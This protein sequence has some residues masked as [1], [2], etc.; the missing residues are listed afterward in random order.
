MI[1]ATFRE[2][3]TKAYTKSMHQFDKGQWLGFE[4]IEFPTNTEVHFSNEDHGGISFAVKTRDSIAKIP[5]VYFAT[6]KYIY[7]WLYATEKSKAT[8]GSISY[9]TDDDPTDPAPDD[10]IVIDQTSASK[11]G[12]DHSYTLYEVV[13]PVIKRP[14]IFRVED[15]SSE[16]NPDAPTEMQTSI[17]QSNENMTIESLG[18]D[19]QGNPSANNYAIDGENFIFTGLFHH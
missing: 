4:G 6:G 18:N 16:E 19:G 13:I 14:D 5:D 11:K 1:I 10:R 2:G 17:D 12:Y 15:E 9:H 8:N 3:Q 7:A